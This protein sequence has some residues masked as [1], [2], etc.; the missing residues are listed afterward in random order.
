MKRWFS[1]YS[2]GVTVGSRQNSF[3][4]DLPKAPG[5]LNMIVSRA[6]WGD[7]VPR[8]IWSTIKVKADHP[9]YKA[10]DNPS[11]APPAMRFYLQKAMDNNPSNRWWSNPQRYVLQPLNEVVSVVMPI[12]PSQWTNVNG[13]P[14]TSAQNKF[15]D[16]WKNAEFFGFTFGAHFFGHGVYLESGKARLKVSGIKVKK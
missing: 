16:A 10:L 2:E 15:F 9:V 3:W 7:A 11:N 12:I 4:V 5:H 1:D 6:W 13:Q 8:E 14:G